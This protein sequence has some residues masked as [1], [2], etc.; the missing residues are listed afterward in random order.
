MENF[1]EVYKC[2]YDY[3]NMEK[4]TEDHSSGARDWLCGLR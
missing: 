3:L 4:E 2:V 1:H